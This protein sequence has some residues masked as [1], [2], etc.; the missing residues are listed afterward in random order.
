M[1]YCAAQVWGL[2]SPDPNFTLE[3]HMKGVNC[4]D[5]FAGGDKPYLI[6]GSDDQ[7]VK[8]GPTMPITKVVSQPLGIVVLAGMCQ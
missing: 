2:G 3:G 1:P 4:L 8:V 6:S 7:L 5:Y